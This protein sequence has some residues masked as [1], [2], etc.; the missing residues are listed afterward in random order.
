MEFDAGKAAK[1]NFYA[2]KVAIGHIAAC[3]GVIGHPLQNF[4]FVVAYICW[5]QTNTGNNYTTVIS[6]MLMQLTASLL[7][8]CPQRRY[9]NLVASR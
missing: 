3:P 5:L 4:I 2:N 6:R 8:Q 1:A 7:K 9:P